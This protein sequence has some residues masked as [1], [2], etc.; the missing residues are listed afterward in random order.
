MGNRAYDALWGTALR[1][2]TSAHR[3]VHKLSGGRLLR[4]LPGGAQVVWITTLGRRSG[5]WRTNPLLGVH[6]EIDGRSGWGIA[7]SNAGQEKVPGWV[8]NVQAHPHGRIEVDGVSTS[9]TFVE[10]TGETAADV[11]ARL[12]KTWSSYRMYE[13]NINRDIPIFVAL[14]DK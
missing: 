11:Y 3:L 12:G 9:C 7:G 8:F 2:T 6:T 10:V 13:R 4:R 14:K 1:T 5:E